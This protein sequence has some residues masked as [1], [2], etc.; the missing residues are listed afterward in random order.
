LLYL[1]FLRDEME[2]AAHRLVAAD[3][4][5]GKVR[6]AIRTAGLR[7]VRFGPLDSNSADVY[8]CCEGVLDE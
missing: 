2:K 1:Q 4:D 5:L 7:G 8:V 3:D 6:A